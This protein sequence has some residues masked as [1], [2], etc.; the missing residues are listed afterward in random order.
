MCLFH[1]PRA[2]IALV[3][4]SHTVE[5][6]HLVDQS[7]IARTGSDQRRQASGRDNLR[8]LLAK[9]FDHV[10]NDSIGQPDV[11]VEQARLDVR[12]C[13]SSDHA[14]RATN[15][16]LWQPRRAHE[17]S[18]GRDSYSGSDDATEI[19]STFGDH[20]ECSRGSEID[21]NTGTAIALECSHAVYDAIRAD[22]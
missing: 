18:F 12:D 9:L 8:L 19:L 1:L 21:H 22:L 20:I 2:G 7:D 4:D 15:I 10:L 3:N 16:Y 17:E 6:Q 14:R 5:G 13:V 11:A